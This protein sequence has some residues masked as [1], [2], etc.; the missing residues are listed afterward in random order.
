MGSIS[1][2]H[3]ECESVSPTA[4]T[5][6]SSVAAQKQF[7][8]EA[9]R[10]ALLG[11]RIGND[12]WTPRNEDSGQGGYWGTCPIIRAVSMGRRNTKRGA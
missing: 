10:R 2:L 6:T 11:K 5:Q 9:A 12:S 7:F 8:F 4:E 3:T 1:L